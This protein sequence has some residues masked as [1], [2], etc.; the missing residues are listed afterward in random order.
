VFWPFIRFIQG[1]AH[2]D[3]GTPGPGIPLIDEAIALGGETNPTAP[4]FHI[5]RG[6]LAL[7]GP[8]ADPAAAAASY[9]RAYAMAERLRAPMPQ[10][11]AAARLCRIATDADRDD[12]MARLRAIHATLTEGFSTPDMAAAAELLA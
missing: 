4:L 8:D 3:A 12:R 9:E 10:L 11:R 7:L 2:A 5:V 1:A 6:D